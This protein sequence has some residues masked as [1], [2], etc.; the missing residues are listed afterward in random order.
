MK[1]FKTKRRVVKTD[2]MYQ[3]QV[4]GLFGNWNNM[5]YF[6]IIE[7]CLYNAKF[8]NEKKPY[9]RDEVRNF[10]D[11]TNHYVKQFAPD[12]KVYWKNSVRKYIGL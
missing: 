9:T 3:C 10:Y 1:L 7:E 6:D 12:A 5:S 4:R 11:S 2:N 8:N